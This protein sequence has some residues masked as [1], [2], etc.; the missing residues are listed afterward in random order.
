MLSVTTAS[1]ARTRSQP[2][3]GSWG[4]DGRQPA[5]RQVQLGRALDEVKAT[6]AAAANKPSDIDLAALRSTRP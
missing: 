2:R 5:G 1:A 4:K 6:M 3:L